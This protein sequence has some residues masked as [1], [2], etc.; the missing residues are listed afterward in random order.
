VARIATTESLL[1]I[2]NCDN[3]WKIVKKK[4][5]HICFRRKKTEL[6]D[7]LLFELGLRD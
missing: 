4:A 6:M 7:N 5:H 2:N 3:S 1:R